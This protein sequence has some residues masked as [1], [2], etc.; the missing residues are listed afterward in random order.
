M[1]PGQVFN[2]E[3]VDWT[4]AQIGNN[5]STFVGFCQQNSVF[6][7]LFSL[8]SD[9]IRD[10]DLSRVHNLS[11][12]VAVEGA[13]PGDCLVVDILDGTPASARSLYPTLSVHSQAI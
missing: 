7:R 1:K 13:E 12:P 5:D 4:G 3:C 9:D 10:V 6:M 8:A 2:V 11:G